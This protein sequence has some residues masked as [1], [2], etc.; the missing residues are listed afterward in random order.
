MRRSGDSELDTNDIAGRE[1]PRA[2]A[3]EDEYDRGSLVHGIHLGALWAGA[4]FKVSLKVLIWGILIKMPLIYYNL[5]HF[6]QTAS[7]SKDFGAF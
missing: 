2:D 5:G 6:G 4:L 1:V 7:N 3:I